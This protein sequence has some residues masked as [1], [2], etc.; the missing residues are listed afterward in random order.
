MTWIEGGM[1]LLQ[2]VCCGEAAYR[3]LG[4]KALYWGG[5]FALTLAV[6]KGIKT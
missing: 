4:W 3:G 5:A 1:L 6:V 2:V